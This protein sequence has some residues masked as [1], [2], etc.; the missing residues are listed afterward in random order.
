MPHKCWICQ[1]EPIFSSQTWM[2]RRWQTANVSASSNFRNCKISINVAKRFMPQ[3]C[4][5]IFRRCVW[6]DELLT[7]AANQPNSIQKIVCMRT[8]YTV[9]AHCKTPCWIL[10]IST[11]SFVYFYHFITD[12]WRRLDKCLACVWA[13]ANQYTVQ[14]QR[15]QQPCRTCIA[16]LR[17]CILRAMPHTR[18]CVR[19]GTGE[20]ACHVYHAAI[21]WLQNHILIVYLSCACM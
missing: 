7:L 4:R 15:K 10:L 12:G 17:V 5:S 21:D 13:C 8:T 20:G 1:W 6:R 2:S 3:R 9:L 16:F 11:R 19:T 18:P 14:W